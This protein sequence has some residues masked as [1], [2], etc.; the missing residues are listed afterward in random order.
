MMTTNDIARSVCASDNRTCTTQQ[1]LGSVRS[2]SASP[3]MT[4]GL[5][6]QH[7]VRCWSL[8][9]SAA[10]VIGFLLKSIRKKYYHIIKPFCINIFLFPDDYCIFIEYFSIYQLIPDS[11]G[12]ELMTDCRQRTAADRVPLSSNSWAL[13]IAAGFIV[14]VVAGIVPRLS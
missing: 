11:T 12:A 14:L 3:P 1:T 5:G 4:S 9:L 7:R 13:A 10:S 8:E 6:S 2:R